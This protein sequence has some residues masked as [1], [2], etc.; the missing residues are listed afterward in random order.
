[1]LRV[2]LNAY[3]LRVAVPIKC[4]PNVI[5]NIVHYLLIVY[6]C[7]QMIH[8]DVK[9]KLHSL[10]SVKRV[11]G[12]QLCLQSLSSL[13]QFSKI[14]FFTLKNSRYFSLIMCRKK[15]SFPGSCKWSPRLGRHRL[16]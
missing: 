11:A 2:G 7:Q 5:L 15:D 3:V 16:K 13:N 4:Y 14:A 8:G 6:Y 10:W 12:A 1:M 9:E